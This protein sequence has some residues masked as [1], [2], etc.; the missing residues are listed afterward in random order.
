MIAYIVLFI[1]ACLFCII[2]GFLLMGGGALFIYLTKGFFF[3]PT[4]Q[5]IR[6][7]VFGC[8][9]GTSITLAAIV[10]NLIDKFNSR[11]KPPSYPE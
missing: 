10:F 6:V 2:S 5:M 8:I 7:I 4:H 1:Y 3:F 11:K 9:A